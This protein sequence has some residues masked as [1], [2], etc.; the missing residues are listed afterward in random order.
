MV[1][2]FMWREDYYLYKDSSYIHDPLIESDA[3]LLIIEPLY[4]M[5][6]LWTLRTISVKR[7]QLFAV[8]VLR[9]WKLS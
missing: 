9:I 8:F 5:L 1:L 4:D 6:K 7:Y 2:R 3:D